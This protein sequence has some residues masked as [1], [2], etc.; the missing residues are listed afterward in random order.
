MGSR[1]IEFY[2][3]GRTWR[4]TLSNDSVIHSARPDKIVFSRVSPQD[5]IAYAPSNDKI[6]YAR[7]QAMGSIQRRSAFK[8]VF[9]AFSPPP[10]T[11]DEVVSA[12]NPVARWRLDE[13]TGTVANDS[14]GTNHGTYAGATLNQ[15]PLINAGTAVLFSGSAS[16]ITVPDAAALD[17]GTV[18][19]VRAWV[20]TSSAAAMTIYDK[21]QSGSTWPGYWLRILAG[22]R[23]SCEVR[24]SNADNPK[25]VATTTVTVNDGAR[26]MIDAVFVGSSALK[27]YIDGVERASVS[28]SIA[29]AWNTA[30][31]L[32]IGTRFGGGEA[33]AGVLDELALF[34][35]AL[36]ES[37]I[38]THYNAGI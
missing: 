28:H 32:Y 22:G 33:Y 8:K 3:D 21:G 1:T 37:R 12:D 24:S 14:V 2:D 16:G 4:N 27:I 6:H 35:T 38:I 13:I 29:S 30:T 26:H 36:S 19:T 7:G 5:S 20:K 10:P 11:Y 23:V 9:V 25:A 17:L 34:A 15:A 31:A 18:F